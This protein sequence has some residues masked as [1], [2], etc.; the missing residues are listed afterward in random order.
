MAEMLVL[1]L[2][3]SSVGLSVGL[4]RLAVGEMYRLVRIDRVPAPTARD[5]AAR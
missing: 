4:S 2:V 1:L 3:L 5:D